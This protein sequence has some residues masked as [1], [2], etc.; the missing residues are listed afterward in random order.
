MRGVPKLLLLIVSAVLL[1]SG[2]SA[3]GD[4]A[5]TGS[6]AAPGNEA[7]ATSGAESGDADAGED[8]RSAAFL[9]PGGD[10]SIQNFGAEAD[11][12]ELE[13]AAAALSGFMEARAE[14][15]WAG[16]CV[17]MAQAAVEP[18]EQLLARASQGKGKGCAAAFEAVSS[19]TPPAARASTL[20]GEVA[21][22]RVD[23]DRGFALYHGPKGID[24]FIPMVKEDGKWKVGDLAPTEFP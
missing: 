9:T 6:T 8:E 4:D 11:A 21:S 13:D 7:P 23:G 22:L 18:L 10:N 20:T 14:D 16:A 17:E 2:F 12:A 1:A 5:D 15:D 19:G 24:Y 3:C